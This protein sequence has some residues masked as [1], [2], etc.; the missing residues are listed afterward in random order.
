MDI[1]VKESSHIPL[2]SSAFRAA[3]KNMPSAVGMGKSDAGDDALL[4]TLTAARGDH[5]EFAKLPALER[6][7]F[8][9]LKHALRAVA[10]FSPGLA[11]HL[12]LKIMRMPPKARPKP[13]HRALVASAARFELNING[14]PAHGYAW[15]AGPAVIFCH[16]WCADA[17]WFAPYVVE[18]NQRGFQVV[19]FDAPGHGLTARGPTD[20]FGFAACIGGASNW[21][22]AQGG[23]VQAVVGHSV[24][25]VAAALAMRDWNIPCDRLALISAFTD[26]NWVADAFIRMTGLSRDIG[27][28]MRKQY[29]S[30]SRE[31]FA[32]KRTSVVDMIRHAPAHV[33]LAHDRDDADVPFWHSLVLLEGCRRAHFYHTRG[34]GHRR[35]LR[36]AGLVNALVR[37]VSS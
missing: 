31:P 34:C 9:I 1:L 2:P 6:R 10:V 18:L 8:A 4:A 13:R 28:R 37:F 26:C 33:F 35:V 15:G 25:G 24:G 3:A 11:A 30:L 36:D 22:M 14:L 12:S 5:I 21:V 32:L 19:A 20:M 23:Q 29:A 16:G 27:E 7:G 17:S